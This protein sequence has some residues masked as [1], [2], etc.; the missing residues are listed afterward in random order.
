[1]WADPMDYSEETMKHAIFYTEFFKNFFL[2]TKSIL[3]RSTTKQHKK[4]GPHEMTFSKYLEKTKLNVD[5]YL[6]SNIDTPNVIKSLHKL[7]SLLFTYVTDVEKKETYVSEEI[8][9]DTISYVK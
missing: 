9:N 6:R 3:L 5:S 7:V 1:N 8:I 2:Q 4:F